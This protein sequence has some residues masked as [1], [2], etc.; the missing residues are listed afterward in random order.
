[1][2]HGR[3]PSTA[4]RTA[5]ADLP[6]DLRELLDRARGGET[7]AE[8]ASATGSSY[9]TVRRRVALALLSVTS[10]CAR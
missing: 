8:I 10:A 7:Y 2:A 9:E 6:G 5:L 3:I 4:A 1:M